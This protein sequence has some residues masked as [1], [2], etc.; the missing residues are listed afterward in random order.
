M[1]KLRA[2]DFFTVVLP[3]AIL[4]ASL[5]FMMNGFD[6]IE[7]ETFFVTAII[8]FLPAY[9][10]IGS[11]NTFLGYHFE[12]WIDQLLIFIKCKAKEHP[13]DKILANYSNVIEVITDIYPE[14]ENVSP[15]RQA[16]AVFEK[17]RVIL[18]QKEFSA[19]AQSVAIQATFYRNLVPVF[20]IIFFMLLVALFLPAEC[21]HPWIH[22]HSTCLIFFTLLF[23]LLS[24]WRS[25]KLFVQWFWEVLNNIDAYFKI[26]K[27]TKS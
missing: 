24:R 3:G 20:L 21:I 2:F 14:L 5:T 22:Q 23:L 12:R 15:E 8:L 17:C 18:Y 11:F 6:Y 26:S 9:M 16:D 13:V 1:D 27:I 10:I 7:S 4:L 19:R 25:Q